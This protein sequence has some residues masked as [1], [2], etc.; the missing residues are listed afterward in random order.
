VTRR[1]GTRSRAQGGAAAALAAAL[2]VGL[3]L[4]AGTRAAEWRGREPPDLRDPRVVASDFVLRQRA[5][6]G[7]APG[8]SVRPL[9]RR[10]SP[11]GTHVRLARLRGGVPILGGDVLVQLA[12][13]GRVG[14]A[15][16]RDLPARAPD[17]GPTVPA[18]E[19]EAAARRASGLG[20]AAAVARIDLALVPQGLALRLA[21]DVWLFADA[22]V[23]RWR[24]LVDA[25][26][27]AILRAHDLVQRLDGAGRA[28]VP[29]PVVALRDNTLT[30]QDDADEAVPEAAYAAVVL[31]DLDPPVGGLFHLRGPAVRAADLEPPFIAPPAEPAPAFTYTRAHDAFEWVMVYVHADGLRRFYQRLGFADLNDRPIEIDAHGLGGA[32]GAHYVPDGNGTGY[33]AF[34]DGGV[35]YAEDGEVILHELGH[36]TQDDQCPSCFAF[37]DSEAGALGEGFADFL[38]AAYFLEASGGFQD[39]CIAD[40]VATGTS[41]ASPPCVRRIDGP[42]RYPDDLAGRPHADGEIWS[43]LFWDL[44]LGLSGGAAPTPA[45]RDT[46]VTLALESHFLVPPD[47]SFY[48]AAQALLDA[49]ALLHGGAHHDLLAATLAG[50]GLLP[51]PQIFGGGRTLT[52]CAGVLLYANPNN[53]DG[54]G[55]RRQTC[56]DND[57]TCDG[58][59]VP[60]ECTF[61][62]SF[63]FAQHGLAG[64]VP[65]PVE[66]FELHKPRPTQ[67]A[68]SLAAIG[69]ALVAAVAAIPGATRGGDH[70]EVVS[71]TPAL[72]APACS[73]AAGLVVPLRRS[74]GVYRRT[75]LALRTVT[76]LPRG[77]RDT[78]R[79]RLGCVP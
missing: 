36:A 43:A 57:P 13:E 40:W 48:E 74:G 58:D 33:L 4:P 44:V 11:A 29:S 73:P 68:P 70:G 6:L 49:E 47:P 42:K 2:L 3:A 19:A 5:A 59:T 12:P 78:D 23:A 15:R 26:D 16:T 30:D 67:R 17:G 52:D 46:V 54:R 22:P 71:W 7:L 51:P 41:S 35:D 72:G 60:G 79:L 9:A 55:S 24:V 8:E 76:V 39:T 18:G 14:L 31:R 20:G 32:A 27:G 25:E 21:W 69:E 37:A 53:P 62:A 34:G 45:A 75:T 64:C 1:T 10:V 65:Q 63:C 66:R 38:A 56:R 61:R 28:F 77:F 50:R